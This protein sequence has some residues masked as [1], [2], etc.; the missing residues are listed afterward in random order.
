[1]TPRSICLALSLVSTL[2]AASSAAAR[3][4]PPWRT[5]TAAGVRSYRYEGREIAPGSTKGY[6]VDFRIRSSAAGAQVAEIIRSATFDGK[7]WTPVTIDPP[8][9]VALHARQGELA[10]IALYPLSAEQAKLGDAFLARCAPA[11]VFFPIT[12]ILN[13]ALILASDRFHL[14]DLRQ[15]GQSA[16]FAG[17]STSLDRLGVTMAESSDGGATSLASVDKDRAVVE[18]KPLP[19]RLDLVERDAAGPGKPV[20]LS[21][22][23]RFAFRVVIDARSGALERAD[24]LYDD[25][26]LAVDVAGL[27]QDKLPHMAIRRTVSIEPLPGA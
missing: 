7:T 17:F 22:T 1:M 5:P 6:R 18:W 8:C 3:P 26:D 10:V 19:A 12:D 4:A 23:E 21:G 27:P 20:H 13:V 9:A 16:A 11:G 14:N 25:L 2:A 24:T 15:A